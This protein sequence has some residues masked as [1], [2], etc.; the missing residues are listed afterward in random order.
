MKTYKDVTASRAHQPEKA[1]YYIF[2]LE[3]DKIHIQTMAVFVSLI[4]PAVSIDCMILHCTG[5]GHG[6][7]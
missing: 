2:H 1:C 7:H 4:K 3:Y 5:I 6:D